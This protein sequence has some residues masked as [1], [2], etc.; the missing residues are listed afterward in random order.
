[1]TSSIERPGHPGSEF[2]RSFVVTMIILTVGTLALFA[3]VDDG[4]DPRDRDQLD[5]RFVW[6]PYIVASGQTI[7]QGMSEFSKAVQEPVQE[8]AHALVLI[9]LVAF[10]VC[11]PTVLLFLWRER[12][13]ARMEEASRGQEGA[14]YAVFI[15]T[16][17]LSGMLF[18]ATVGGAVTQR[19][20]YADLVEAQT[21][22]SNKDQLINVINDV[23]WRLRQHRALP[24][25]MGG[26]EGSYDGFE[27]QAEIA[28][29]T[30]GTVMLDIV[31]DDVTITAESAL[32]EGSTVGAIYTPDGITSWTFE[33]VFR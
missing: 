32:F 15:V 10:Y 28:A 31:P 1:M 12:S 22:Q 19:M 4:N 33:G 8:G 18:V 9:G 17:I 11:V 30:H 5:A 21:R 13:I 20:A 3:L 29:S 16:A 26:G 7:S 27:L 24:R 25:A 6:A 23:M 2:S 14:A